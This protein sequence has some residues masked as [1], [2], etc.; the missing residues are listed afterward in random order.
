MRRIRY[1]LSDKLDK[2]AKCI[3]SVM[4]QTPFYVKFVA[5][6]HKNVVHCEWKI[7]NFDKILLFL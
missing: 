7:T 6:V 2:Y 5:K 3:V 1:C 4:R